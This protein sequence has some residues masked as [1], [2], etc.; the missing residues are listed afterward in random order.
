MSYMETKCSYNVTCYDVI[1]VRKHIINMQEILH[2]EH[3]CRQALLIIP[4][5]PLP[6]GMI[7]VILDES[8]IFQA[9]QDYLDIVPEC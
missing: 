7:D 6:R 8:R 5:T 1:R 3:T 4:A 9:L 2:V